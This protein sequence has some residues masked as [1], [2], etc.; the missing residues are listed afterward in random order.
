MLACDWNHNIHIHL[1]IHPTS[2]TLLL[3]YCDWDSLDCFWY[4]LIILFT[5]ISCI[6]SHIHH[7]FIVMDSISSNV[8][9]I[10]TSWFISIVTAMK[11]NSLNCTVFINITSSIREWQFAAIREIP[12]SIIETFRTI[13]TCGQ[14]S[15]ALNTVTITGSQ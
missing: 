9:V 1:S 12:A 2:S 7:R 13:T 14:V 5:S 11:V 15:V 6:Q 10:D 3:F 8:T 4:I